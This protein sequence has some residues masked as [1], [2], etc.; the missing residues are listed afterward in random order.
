VRP[1][2]T[3]I[4]PLVLNA[5]QAGRPGRTQWRKL[6]DLY[7]AS[8]ILVPTV[9]LVRQYPGGPVV[10][11]FSA[12]HGPDGRIVARFSLSAPD[13]DALPRMLD[14]GVRRL[15]DAYARALRGGGLRSDSSLAAEPVEVPDLPEE[16]PV[17]GDEAPV[18]AA[19]PGAASSFVVQ[20][21]TPDDPSLVQAQAG[22]RAVP[23][24]RSINTDSVALGGISVM[25]LVFAGD[26]A[27]LRTAL[28][29]AGYTVDDAGGGMRLRRTR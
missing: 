20:I 10:A 7:G 5:A 22:L 12:I 2:G 13:T 3:G 21:E 14:E 1:A 25:R 17:E 16:A 8:D 29:A 24:V 18:A 11:N 6:L 26:A 27:T 19:L 15:D 9:Q 4:D 28:A 23:G